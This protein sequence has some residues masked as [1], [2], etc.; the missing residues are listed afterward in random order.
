MKY[1]IT[2]D[3]MIYIFHQVIEH[4]D[5]ARDIWKEVHSA[6]FTDC[7]TCVGKSVWLWIWSK[8]GEK[9]ILQKN[10]NFNI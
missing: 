5:M 3:K 4:K 2:K 8:P 10:L 7:K 6:W 1:I 9:E